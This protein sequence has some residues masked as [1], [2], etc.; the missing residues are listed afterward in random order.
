MTPPTRNEY[1]FGQFA[2]YRRHVLDI[3]GRATREVILFDADLKETGLESA[4]GIAALEAFFTRHTVPDCV[5]VV[6]HDAGFI[7]RECPRLL[8]LLASFGHRIRIRVS[9]RQHAAIDQAFIVVDGQ[10]V[11]TRFHRDNA[12]G[13]LILDDGVRAAQLADLFDTVWENAQQGP[14]GMPLGL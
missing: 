11:L 12:R 7:E 1:E 3:L 9:A 4:A 14:T 10:H 6:V 8:R 2:D 5:R 13:K